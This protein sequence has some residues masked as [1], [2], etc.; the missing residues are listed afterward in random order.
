[1]LDRLA[2]GTVQEWIAQA[3][4]A[5]AGRLATRREVLV[6][7]NQYPDPH[8]LPAELP[9]RDETPAGAVPARRDAVPFE[10]LRRRV[11][12]LGARDPEAGRVFC[13]CLGD[14][15][16]YM[17]RLE[18]ARRFF[19]VGGFEVGDR[20]FATTVAEAVAAATADGART[21]VLVGLDD[22]YA[23][24]AAPVAEALKKQPD[25]PVVMLAGAPVDIDAVDEV[26]N[27]KSDVLDVLDRD[28]R[29]FAGAHGRLDAPSA[30]PAVAC[31]AERGSRHRE[32]WHVER[33]D[34]AADHQ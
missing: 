13:V 17:P 18:F 24:L 21:V 25:P 27:V 33:D 9:A 7:T 11:E 12:D 1:M 19:R 30:S 20:G 8:P 22:T 29:F 5:R 23:D 34:D 26:I 10:D 4:A 3:A 6:G 15:A 14:V 2:A 28:A 16:R 31:T 32:E